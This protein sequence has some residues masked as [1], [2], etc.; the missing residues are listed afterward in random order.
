M[1]LWIRLADNAILGSHSRPSGPSRQT[2]DP[3][4]SRDHNGRKTSPANRAYTTTPTSLGAGTRNSPH[5]PAAHLTHDSRNRVPLIH[6]SRH[7]LGSI[8]LHR[9]QPYGHTLE[10]K[11]SQ[12]T[13]LSG[14][15]PQP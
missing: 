6:S 1:A 9:R 10:T 5:T 3:T 14:T 13:S 7:K 4:S 12:R 15:H 2:S 11:L 8:P